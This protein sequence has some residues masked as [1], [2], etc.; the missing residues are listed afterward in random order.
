MFEK[1]IESDP[2]VRRE[3]TILSLTISAFLH[4]CTLLV[5]T[6]LIDAAMQAA[7]QWEYE[8]TYLNDVAYLVILN[9]TVNFALQ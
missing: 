1:L 7:R 8:P 6:M 9:I 4:A 2:E 5:A 3:K